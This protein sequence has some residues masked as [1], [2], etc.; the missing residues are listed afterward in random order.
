MRPEPTSENKTVIYPK[1]LNE[2]HKVSILNKRYVRPPWEYLL[3]T[4]EKQETALLHEL[5]QRA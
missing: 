5:D 3:Q 1:L 4:K 2:T